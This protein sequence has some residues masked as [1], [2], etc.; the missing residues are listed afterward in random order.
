MP[1]AQRTGLRGGQ[2]RIGVG[3]TTVLLGLL[4]FSVLVIFHEAG[5]FLMA[6]LM[7]VRVERFSIGFGPVVLRRRIAEVEYA[8][9]AFPLGGY[10]KMGGDDPRDRAAL[11]PGDFFAAAWW[12]RVLIA[13]A[14]PG[15]NFVLAILLG[16]VLA[17]VGFRSPDAASRVGHV[18][19]GSDAAELGFLN[20]DMITEVNGRAVETRSEV[21][22]A[23]LAEPRPETARLSVERGGMPVQMEVP[24]ERV[25]RLLGSL[26]FFNPATVGEVSIGS[27]AYRAGM[28]VGDTVVAVDEQPVESWSDLTRL[29]RANP[30]TEITFTVEREGKRVR[31]PVTPTP[32]EENGERFGRVGIL[33]ASDRT[34]VESYGFVEGIG[35]GFEVAVRAVQLTAGGI[36]ALVTNFFTNVSQISGPVAIIQASGAAAKAGIDALLNFAIVISAALMVFNL[37]PIPILD[38]GMV[39]LSILEGLRRRPIGERG[40]AVYQGIGLAVVGTLLIFV[41]INDPLRMVQ[42]R[43]AMDRAT[44]V[45][46]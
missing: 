4:V 17:W 11:K 10:V 23:L 15:A 27:P 2:E 42:R 20:G 26:T 24:T 12:R 35:V 32:V 6:R 8:V 44:E 43:V 9:S 16:I 34:Y 46:P 33:A 29:I 40:L 21:W 5:H 25:E 18:A 14:G 31:F 3:M 7:G 37:L 1:S 22:H 28:K 30:D 36:A 45:A 19:E 39:V 41:L 13:L 38:G